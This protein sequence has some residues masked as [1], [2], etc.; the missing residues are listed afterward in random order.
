MKQRESAASFFSLCLYHH[1]S[2]SLAEG[3][4]RRLPAIKRSTHAGT[5]AREI[6]TTRKNEGEFLPL[7]FALRASPR[8]RRASTVASPT[9]PTACARVLPFTTSNGPSGRHH[10]GR[11]RPVA[12]GRARAARRRRPRAAHGGGVAAEEVSVQRCVGNG[13]GREGDMARRRHNFVFVRVARGSR[14]LRT[15][16]A[17]PAVRP[18]YFPTLTP[19]SLSTQSPSASPACKPST[20]CAPRRRAR[21]R[22]C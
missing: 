19:A 15:R 2:F 13:D 21:T 5:G 17:T 22:W 3:V 18:W 4:V 9:G 12:V 16:G 1:H 14:T 7:S 6:E 11:A 20:S 8:A 10:G